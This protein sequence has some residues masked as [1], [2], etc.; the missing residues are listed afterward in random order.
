MAELDLVGNN[1]KIGKK[2]GSGSFGSVY[3]CVSIKSG[4]AYAVKI[5]AEEVTAS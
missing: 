3:S 4:K 5:E 1:Y 2:I